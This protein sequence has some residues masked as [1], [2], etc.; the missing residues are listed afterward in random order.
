M[1]SPFCYIIPVHSLKIK[2]NHE[3]LSKNRLFASISAE[4]SEESPKNF[5]HLFGDSSSLQGDAKP[6]AVYWASTSLPAIYGGKR[7]DGFKNFQRMVS[8]DISEDFRARCPYLPQDELGA[9]G[10]SEDDLECGEVTGRWRGFMR[11]QIARVRY[12]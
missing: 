4:S 9:Y 2:S 1:A 7:I 10:L 3:F 11:F 5:K 8:Y 12:L 6:S